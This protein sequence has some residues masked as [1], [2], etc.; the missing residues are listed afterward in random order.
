M[1]TRLLPLFMALAMTTGCVVYE[2]DGEGSNGSSGWTHAG[3]GNGGADTATDPGTTAAPSYTLSLSPG[4]AVPGQTTIV[5]IVAE[6]D[7]DLTQ[8]SSV[9]FFGQSNVS[10]VATSSRSASEFLL[11]ISVPAGATL[12]DNDMLVTMNDGTAIYVKLAFVVVATSAEIPNDP[13][14]GSGSGSGTG[15]GGSGTDDTAAGCP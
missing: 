5:S 1:T 2:R 9:A 7:I 11:T 12:G 14:A 8:V 4:G 3:G 15:S 13:N 10:V 6:G